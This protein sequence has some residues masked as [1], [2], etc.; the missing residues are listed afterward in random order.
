MVT[1]EDMCKQEIDK[2]K[3]E[4]LKEVSVIHE[5]QESHLKDIL[6]IIKNR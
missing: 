2:L 3:E 4:H 1:Y 5:K 6:S